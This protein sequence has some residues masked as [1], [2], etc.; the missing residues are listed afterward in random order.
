MKYWQVTRTLGK[1]LL[2][3]KPKKATEL[4]NIFSFLEILQNGVWSIQ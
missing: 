4:E 1:R 3:L 2:H